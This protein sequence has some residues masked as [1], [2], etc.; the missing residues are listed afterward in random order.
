[1]EIQLV[2]LVTGEEIIAD[3]DYIND[4][5]WVLHN[6]IILVPTGPTETRIFSFPHHGL[7][8]Q[9][10]EVL[11]QHIVFA[12]TPNDLVVNAYNQHNGNIITAPADKLLLPGGQ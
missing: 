10:L 4:N 2:H 6:P 11:R 7:T 9:A 8:K 5:L 1:M 3:V 12:C